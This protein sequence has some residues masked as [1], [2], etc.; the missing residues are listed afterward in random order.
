MNTK[1][2]LSGF[3]I[4]VALGLVVAASAFA[5]TMTGGNMTG[6][7]MTGGNMTGDNVTT[8]AARR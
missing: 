5:K 3:A 1:I 6:G 8:A 2:F 7:N 4:L